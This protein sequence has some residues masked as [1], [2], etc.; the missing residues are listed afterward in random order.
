GPLAGRL[1]RSPLAGPPRLEAPR[2]AARR[3]AGPGARV[4]R[5]AGIALAARARRALALRPRPR[6]ALR[7]RRG[8]RDDAARQAVP[9]RARR[10]GRRRAVAD[11][12]PRARRAVAA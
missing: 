9:Q 1:P 8:D 12:G 6:G 2:P 4:R 5:T 3:V 10:P 11:D 7:R